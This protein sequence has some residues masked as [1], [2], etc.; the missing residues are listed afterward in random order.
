MLWLSIEQNVRR[1]PGLP[2][3]ELACCFCVSLEASAC[4]MPPKIHNNRV[5]NPTET[6]PAPVLALPA[7]QMSKWD[8][9]YA[10]FLR[11]LPDL[12]QTHRGQYVA[13]HEGKVVD[14]GDDKV[15]VALRAYDKY[16]YLPIY[17]G[18]VAERPLKPVRVP[19]FHIHDRP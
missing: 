12:L 15:A 10:A 9:E 17:V 5:M 16:G 6:L 14:S 18:L 1:P 2:T 8:Q 7:P 4:L 11:M 19:Q 3:A 13:V